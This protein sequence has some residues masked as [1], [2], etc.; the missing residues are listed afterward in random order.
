MGSRQ[1]V[2]DSDREGKDEAKQH[3]VLPLKNYRPE[4]GENMTFI[5]L[6]CG[7]QGDLA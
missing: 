1:S 6:G 4:L 7:G 2:R 3:D 5:D